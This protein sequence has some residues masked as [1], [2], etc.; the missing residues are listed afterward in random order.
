M[1]HILASTTIL[2]RD[3]C[4]ELVYYFFVKKALSISETDRD[5][6]SNLNLV[7]QA[8]FKGL[9]LSGGAPCEIFLHFKH[10]KMA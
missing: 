9:V 2:P 1:Y 8:I 5:D 10:S 4:V 3:I 7:G 6:G